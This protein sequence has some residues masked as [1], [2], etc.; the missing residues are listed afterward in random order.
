MISISY[1]KNSNAQALKKQSF[2]I[3]CGEL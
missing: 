2:I 3:G 1:L